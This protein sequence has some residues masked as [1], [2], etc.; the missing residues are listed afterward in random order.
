MQCYSG[1]TI[2]RLIKFITRAKPRCYVADLTDIIIYTGG[3][4]AGNDGVKDLIPLHHALK[5]AI[6][7]INP[8][9]RFHWCL[10]ARPPAQ[11]ST[12]RVIANY[13]QF[14]MQEYSASVINT[15]KATQGIPSAIFPDGIH[16]STLALN[17]MHEYIK[18]YSCQ[19]GRELIRKCGL[20]K[21]TRFTKLKLR[22]IKIK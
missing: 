12:D 5:E 18:D 22:V 9:V 4:D 10:I 7:H 16:M 19:R 3:N 21:R 1:C 15:L 14:L 17:R 20:K 6:L 8:A 13:N 11:P 2:S